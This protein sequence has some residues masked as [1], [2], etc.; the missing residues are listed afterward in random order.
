MAYFPLFIDLNGRKCVVIGGGRV[1][2]RKVKTLLLYGADVLVISP[3]TEGLTAE[4]L[5]GSPDAEAGEHNAGVSDYRVIKDRLNTEEMEWE[6]KDAVLVLAAADD[7]QVNH[8]AAAICHRLGIPVN[9]ADEPSECTF[10]FPA[11]VKRGDISIGINTGGQSPVMSS[12]IRKETEKAVPEYY[13]EL[14]RQLGELRSRIRDTVSEGRSRSRYLKE[15]AD[16]AVRH[17]RA[18][19]AEEIDDIL[20]K[21]DSSG[22]GRT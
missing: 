9:V 16:L 18:L 10:L 17:K 19:S 7:R 8:Q 6:I 14:T 1:A 4:G 20:K 2:A 3:G 11:V 12:M 21:A 13:T 22:M 15:A 5:C